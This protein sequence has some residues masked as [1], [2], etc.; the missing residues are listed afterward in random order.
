MFGRQCRRRARVLRSKGTWPAPAPTD[1]H[2]PLPVS[3]SPKLHVLADVVLHPGVRPERKKRPLLQ[4]PL[5][6]SPPCL[7]SWSMVDR[8]GWGTLPPP[9]N[10]RTF[11]FRRGSLRPIQHCSERARVVLASMPRGRVEWTFFRS[12]RERNPF[13]VVKRG[14]S[15]RKMR[16]SAGGRP[17]SRPGQNGLMR[18]R[19]RRPTSPTPSD[20]GRTHGGPAVSS[21]FTVQQ[22]SGLSSADGG[23]R[24]RSC[25]GFCRDA[26]DGLGTV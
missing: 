4:F 9:R 1:P 10:K 13:R 14:N 20:G 18:M 5:C 25:L 15:N 24:R 26:R 12:G 23:G 6:T 22:C 3:D 16:P 8:C 17:R 7:Q 19:A 11:P 21:V 2:L